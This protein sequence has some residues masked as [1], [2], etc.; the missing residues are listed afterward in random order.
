MAMLNNQRVMGWGK[1]SLSL[2]DSVKTAGDSGENAKL[3]ELPAVATTNSW[4]LW[5]LSKICRD[6]QAC[7]EDSPSM[8]FSDFSLAIRILAA[9]GSLDTWRWK[10]REGCSNP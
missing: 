4:R 9:A 8:S 3:P 2:L 1:P 10:E 7:T 5:S 6:W